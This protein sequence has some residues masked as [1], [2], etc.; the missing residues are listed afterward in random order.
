MKKNKRCISLMLGFVL[1]VVWMW[2]AVR[3]DA[4]TS[5][6]LEQSIKEK[7]SAIS[8]AQEE[9]KQLQ[10]TMSNIQAMVDSLESSKNDL[11][12][13]VKQ[14]DGNLAEIQSKIDELKKMISDKE[15]EI[16]ETQQML[17]EAVERE[18]E[19]YAA[20]KVRIQYAYEKGNSNSLEMLLSAKSFGELLNNA[21]YM[22]EMNA[23]DQ[24][25]LEE[26]Q[27][28]RELVETCKTALEEEQEVLQQAKA[29][30]EKEE[31]GLET[32]IS[33]KEQQI[34]AFQGDIS[35]KEAALK[36]YEADIA[37]QN[38]TIAALEAAAA[39]ER[40]QL[41][42]LN[43][44]KVTYD[45]GMFQLPLTSY[46]RISDEYGYRMHPTL[47]VQKFHNGVDFAAPSGTPILAAYGGTV[48]G[49]AY[50]SS[51]SNYVMINH[52][53]GL[54]TIYMHASA[55]YVSQGQTVSKGEQ[56]AAVG[57]TGRSTG[58]HLHFSVRV[59]GEYVNPWNYLK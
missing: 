27:K 40:K 7:E 3:S 29:E 53:D 25:Q 57:S 38:S 22:E 14:L 56:I 37:A 12:A 50:N 6:E 17:D 24:R 45:G 26:Y 46:K 15:E 31:A 4:A 2:P 23:Y 48:V 59:N 54:Y 43:K 55:L 49:A 51:M 16:E 5:S 39:A 44:P 42:E 52:G 8:Q 30:V 32:L 21:N 1:F 19:Q 13:Y 41:E 35:N 20:M 28:N 47:G 10:S 33:Q 11:E 58:P 9:K 36:E 34:T 18:K